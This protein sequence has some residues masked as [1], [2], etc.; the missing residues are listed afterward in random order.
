M[1]LQSVRGYKLTRRVTFIQRI[2]PHYRVP[3]FSGL[4]RALDERGISLELVYGQERAGT[5]PV[6]ESLVQPWATRVENSY[7]HI[8]GVDLVWQPSPVS[9]WGS[10]LVI[11]EQANSLLLNYLLHG[12]RKPGVRRLAY[13]G[14]GCNMQAKRRGNAA[15]KWKR[16]WMSRVDW[17]FAYTEV[18][19]QKVAEAGFPVE[20]T[21]VVNNAIDTQELLEA[22]KCVS[23]ED[24]Q[25]LR[26]RLRIY[27]GR[28]FIY[29]GGLYAD[30][31][32]DFLVRAAHVIRAHI[33]DFHL[34]VIGSGPDSKTIEAASK[35]SGWIHFVGPKFGVER[36]P[37]Y[38]MSEAVL[39]PGLV[40]LAILDSFVLGVP[41]F[42][43][44][45]GLHSPEI[46]YLE[47]HENA[48]MTPPTV[49]AYAEAVVRYI[50]SPSQH[51]HLREGCRR[52]ASSY[53]LNSMIKNFSDGIERC[54]DVGAGGADAAGPECSVASRNSRG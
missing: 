34:V 49:D 7:W 14:H 29:C 26:G 20:R 10:D 47:N 39:M 5:V 27:D 30:K 41:L 42:T 50:E 45:N 32:L 22:S 21:T 53:T 36:V 4:H 51:A 6:S 52:S 24:I 43:T 46:S 13:Y 15:A 16:N 11:V 8:A 48:V 33:P 25:A 2:L 17:W 1:D 12:W 38:L 23:W 18:T 31:R 9:V 54:L 35:E 44:D 28:V 40:G 37:Y 3:F 19:R